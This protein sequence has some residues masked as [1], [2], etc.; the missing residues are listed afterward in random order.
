MK[1]NVNIHRMTKEK[2]N[3][4]TS[5]KRVTERYLL[6][7]IMFQLFCLFFIVYLLIAG[8]LLFGK[9][10]CLAVPAGIGI[11]LNSFIYIKLYYRNREIRNQLSKG[12]E[13][14]QRDIL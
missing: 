10:H 2:I 9:Q 8:H 5:A 6:F 3:T 12:T 11:F 7:W 1:G 14:N 13:L 4:R